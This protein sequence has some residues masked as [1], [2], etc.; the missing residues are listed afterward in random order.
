MHDAFGVGIGAKVV[1]LLI[2]VGAQ[3]LVV[4]AFTVVDNGDGFIFVEDG[5][6]AAGHVDDRQAAHG[7][8]YAALLVVALAI[9]PAVQ[10]GAVHAAQV[11]AIRLPLAAI[12]DAADTAHYLGATSLRIRSK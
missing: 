2:Q 3:L 11:G 12:H 8:A 4:V 9:R 7:Q 10:N 5:L 6:V 1:V